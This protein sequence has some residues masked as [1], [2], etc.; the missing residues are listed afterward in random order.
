M[1]APIYKRLTELGYFVTFVALTTAK[2]YLE[3]LNI[4]SIGYADMEEANE[5][6]AIRWGLELTR[7]WSDDGIVS[8]KETIAYHGANF[9]DLVDEYGEITARQRYADAG[10]HAFLPIT[11]MLRVIKRFSPH[12][13]LATNSPRSERAAIIA[14]GQLGI[15]SVCLVDLFAREEVK[16]IG[17]SGFA[18][19]VCVLNESV[20]D[21]FLLYGRKEFEIV[22]TGNPAFDQ[23][24]S[25]DTAQ[26][27]T[28]LRSDRGWNDGKKV[29]LWASQIEPIKHPFN[30]LIGDPTLPR[31]VEAH[32]RDIVTSNQN[33]RLVVRYHPSERVNFVETD[34][35]EF[36][37]VSESISA[38]LFAV[39]VVVVTA[40]TVG[41]EAFIMGRP[42]ISIDLSV[43]TQDNQYSS[44]GVS[45]GVNDLNDL[46]GVLQKVLSNQESNFKSNNIIKSST[47]E[48]I[49]VINSILNPVQIS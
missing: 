8:L 7:E 36:S 17:Q 35:V 29:I 27:G 33:L 41:L 18:T 1:C 23:L 28:K 9:R 22:V 47:Q 24:C 15:P 46:F 14:A 6:D 4:P 43:F 31:N 34:R 48:I 12:L 30:N 26:A 45:E 20:R 11:T 19:R 49:N 5:P 13:L 10:R 16:W 39:D 25:K 21:M 42:V 37:P 40:S 32:L 44:I 2:A 3:N 38:L